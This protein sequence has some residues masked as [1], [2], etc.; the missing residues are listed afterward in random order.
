MSRTIGP[1]D[2]ELRL[3]QGQP[4]PRKE[5]GRKG[6]GGGGGWIAVDDV[7][8][9]RVLD[10]PVAR[11]YLGVVTKA[12]ADGGLHLR[13]HGAAAEAAGCAAKARLSVMSICSLVPPL[14]MHAALRQLARSPPTALRGHLLARETDA[15]T[16]VA[17]AAA[18]HHAA[19][20]ALAAPPASTR[21]EAG[22]AP[23]SAL[24]QLRAG[25]SS[26]LPPLLLPAAGGGV[27]VGAAPSPTTLAKWPDAFRE[28]LLRA[29]LNPSQRDARRAAPP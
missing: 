28:G 25:A 26:A 2:V 14:R 20:A 13:Q 16:A 4:L 29:R 6:G 11:A 1:S 9:I 19:A 21:P 18:A 27:G 5:G 23:P 7:V 10:A 15:P 22:A 8:L 17:A 3:A 12:E 24:Q